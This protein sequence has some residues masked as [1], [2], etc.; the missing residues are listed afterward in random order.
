M[1]SGKFQRGR[2]GWAV[3]LLQFPVRFGNLPLGR[4]SR[5]YQHGSQKKS[6]KDT[7]Q[8]AHDGV[9]GYELRKDSFY[10]V[11]FLKKTLYLQPQILMAR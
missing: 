7:E 8:A 5:Q 4:A 6:Q 2:G 9:D 3:A 1:A 10:A 11:R